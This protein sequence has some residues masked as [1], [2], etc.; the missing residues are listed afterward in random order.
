MAHVNTP[1]I[2]DEDTGPQLL[3]RAI[4]NSSF[5]AATVLATGCPELWSTNGS[6]RGFDMPYSFWLNNT[7]LFSGSTLIDG[8][9]VVDLVLHSGSYEQCQF[10][11]EHLL[12]LRTASTSSASYLANLRSRFTGDLPG[13]RDWL[14]RLKTKPFREPG[15][16]DDAMPP[17]Y[18]CP[19]TRDEYLTLLSGNILRSRA[20]RRGVW[21]II[22]AQANT[23]HPR[24][25]PHLKDAIGYGNVEAVRE[26]LNRGW[27]VQSHRRFFALTSWSSLLHMDFLMKSSS[28]RASDGLIE[29]MEEDSPPQIRVPDAGTHREIYDQYLEYHSTA[30]QRFHRERLREIRQLLVDRG[31][32]KPKAYLNFTVA[33]SQAASETLQAWALICYVLVYLVVLPIALVYGTTDTWTSMTHGQKVG[34]SYLWSA[35]A[36]IIGAFATAFVEDE[37]DMGWAKGVIVYTIYAILFVG[38]HFAL[39]YAIIRLNWSPL[40]ACSRASIIDGA[41]VQSCTNYSFLMPIAIFVFELIGG[42]LLL[43]AL[44]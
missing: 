30:I 22:E 7:D 21:D 20:N 26:M 9:T 16:N 12:P 39:P 25:I 41:L 1:L 43:I 8:G 35:L 29:A 11:L 38:N 5:K 15:A 17:W 36:G 13:C 34:F 42:S 44:D 23:G 33:F 18:E 2:V 27:P 37:D 4:L 31:A 19:L 40:F 6:L 32:Q 3:G 10:V 14:G 24:S 28:L